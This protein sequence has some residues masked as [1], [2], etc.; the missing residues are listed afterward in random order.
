MLASWSVLVLAGQ[1]RHHLPHQTPQK[2]HR[3]LH[4]LQVQEGQHNSWVC[5]CG[6]GGGVGWVWKSSCWSG[7]WSERCH[8]ACMQIPERQHAISAS[9]CRLRLEAVACWVGAALCQQPAVTLTFCCKHAASLKAVAQ[10]RA[11]EHQQQAAVADSHGQSMSPALSGVVSC[12]QHAMDLATAAAARQ[13]VFCQ[14][15]CSPCWWCATPCLGSWI[16]VSCG[17]SLF[18][19]AW[20]AGGREEVASILVV[21]T[22]WRGRSGAAAERC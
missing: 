17:L 14:S 7:Q 19:G 8:G 9:L 4:H 22:C 20:L 2:C 6:G 21:T 1:N 18:C 13:A 3:R 5:V 11:C 12:E 15:G 10:K 16:G